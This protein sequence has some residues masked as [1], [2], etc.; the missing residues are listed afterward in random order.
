MKYTIL[1]VVMTFSNFC[2]SSDSF[3][4]CTVEDIRLG[5]QPENGHVKL[6][7]EITY[8]P[9]CSNAA[10]QYVAF[11][12][13]TEE[14]KQRLSLFLTAFAGNFK[15]T[16]KVKQDCPAWQTNV[17]LLDSVVLKK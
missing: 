16:G 9:S 10:K 12:K 7:C 17:A 2:H 15:V 11:D 4:D 5:S 13:T 6:S 3:N 14:G 1:V 8:G